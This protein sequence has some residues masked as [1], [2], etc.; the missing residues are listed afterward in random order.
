MAFVGGR[1]TWEIGTN[2]CQIESQNSGQLGACCKGVEKCCRWRGTEE[3]M[4][5]TG[6]LAAEEVALTFASIGIEG[7][8]MTDEAVGAVGL[9]GVRGIIHG[10]V[11]VHLWPHTYYGLA[12]THNCAL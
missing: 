4:H 12:V 7:G 5:I 6:I 11:R 3:L 2:Q 1:G 10:P 9:H 8:L